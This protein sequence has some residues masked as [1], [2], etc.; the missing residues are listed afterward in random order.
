MFIAELAELDAAGAGHYDLS[1]LRTGMMAG[2]PCPVEV[3]K[4]VMDRMGMTEVTIGYGMTETSPI[5]TQTRTDDSLDRRVSTVGRVHP[6]VEIK[7][8]D[9]ETGDDGAARRARRVLHARLLGDA[10]LLGPAGQDGRSHR[11]RR[12]GCTPATWP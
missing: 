8:V 12:A 6:H 9:P 4:Q 1:S 7:I 3:M 2:S 10:R 11:R 5:S